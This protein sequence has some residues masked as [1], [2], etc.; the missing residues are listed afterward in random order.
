[1]G[2]ERARNETNE[3]PSRSTCA[4][5]MKLTT[6]QRR[7]DGFYFLTLR[8][9]REIARSTS[10]GAAKR[11]KKKQRYKVARI[12]EEK[13]DQS[14]RCR[15]ILVHASVLF[16]FIASLSFSVCRTYRISGWSVQ[17]PAR[18][19]IYTACPGFP[20][21]FPVLRFGSLEKE[22]KG[23]GPS[24]AFQA[25]IACAASS[26]NRDSRMRLHVECGGRD[27]E[28]KTY[29]PT[30]LP[31]RCLNTGFNR[32]RARGSRQLAVIA[33]ARGPPRRGTTKRPR[34][35]CIRGL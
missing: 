22:R 15:S 6:S 27:R 9:P 31:E 28:K 35:T 29:V 21:S 3:P 1:M 11:R 4:N 33:H 18:I 24:Q 7:I 17:F 5:T 12:K 19:V 32:H 26:R 34:H 16:L 10:H 13:I 30:M 23:E 2:R 14:R 25:D 8:S 20:S